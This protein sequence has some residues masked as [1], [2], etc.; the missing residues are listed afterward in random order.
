M[1]RS[2]QK[3]FVKDLAANIAKGIIADIHK[4]PEDW[5]GN[6]LR[7]LIADRAHAATINL[8]KRLPKRFRDYKKT[9]DISNL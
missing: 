3:K 4:I 5:D 6:E 9:I 8:K 7:Q 2:E 1:K